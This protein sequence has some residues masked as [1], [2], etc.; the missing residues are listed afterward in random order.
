MRLARFRRDERIGIG[1]VIGDEL[2]DLA[3]AEPSLPLDLVELFANDTVSVAACEVAER[4]TERVALD[5]V[6]L[7]CPIPRPGKFLAIGLNYADHIAETGRSRRRSRCSSTSRSTCVIG[8]GDAI[9]G[10]ASRRSS[11]TRASSAS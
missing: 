9:H 2:V 11:T 3:R 8:P 1:V 6:E 4:A 7:L 10:R 5:Q